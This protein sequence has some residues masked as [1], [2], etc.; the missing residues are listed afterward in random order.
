MMSFFLP[1]SP[2]RAWVEACWSSFARVFFFCPAEHTFAT[3]PCPPWLIWVETASHS[4]S[5]QLTMARSML[6]RLLPHS[7]RLPCPQGPDGQ[8][9]VAA[10]LGISMGHDCFFPLPSGTCQPWFS[11]S[12]CYCVLRDSVSCVAASI[13]LTCCVITSHQLALMLCSYNPCHRMGRPLLE[14]RPHTLFLVH[15]LAGAR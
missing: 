2:S 13:R 3:L 8:S 10:R 6:P 15:F 14:A 11:L 12:L 5:F 7:T 1:L 4:L 9:F